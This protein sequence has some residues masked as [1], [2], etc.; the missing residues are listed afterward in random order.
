MVQWDAKTFISI[1]CCINHP[2]ESC[3]QLETHQFQSSP[4]V[5]FPSLFFNGKCVWRSSRSAFCW[6]TGNNISGH[7]KR[8]YFSFPVFFSKVYFPHRRRAREKKKLAKVYVSAQKVAGNERVP[9]A[10]P[11]WYSPLCLCSAVPSILVCKVLYLG[12]LI[13]TLW[14]CSPLPN[15]F[16]S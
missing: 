12:P 11:G 15:I 13:R 8:H 7:Y 5:Q 2:V 10:S 6:S 9:T 14:I 3:K 16:L 4:I 1:H